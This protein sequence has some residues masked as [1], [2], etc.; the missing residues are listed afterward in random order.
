MSMSIKKVWLPT[1]SIHRDFF[2]SSRQ[3]RRYDRRQDASHLNVVMRTAIRAADAWDFRRLVVIC[4]ESAKKSYSSGFHMVPFHSPSPNGGLACGCLWNIVEQ[5]EITNIN[6]HKSKF[7]IEAA[8]QGF[9]PSDS[10]PERPA[11]ARANQ[12][13]G[14]APGLLDH[15]GVELPHRL[16]RVVSA[17]YEI[18]G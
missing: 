16:T 12:D 2:F 3:P 5:R 14:M 17:G 15:I 11:E 6:H 9:P 13:L 10:M 8:Q 1:S 7:P 4:L 18:Y